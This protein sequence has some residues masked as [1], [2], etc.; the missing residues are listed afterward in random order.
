MKRRY[1]LTVAALVLFAGLF[2]VLAPVYQWALAP[3]SLNPPHT[4]PTMN[5]SPS[6]Y[7]LGFGLVSI[8]ICGHQSY[9]F[10]WNWGRVNFNC[11]T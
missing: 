1:K 2:F 8:N 4:P 9:F 11:A 7:Y 6:Y 10:E 5:V 3:P